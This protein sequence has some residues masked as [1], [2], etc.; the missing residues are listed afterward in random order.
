MESEQSQNFNE[1]LSQWVAN[2]GF[3]FQVR[4]S[5]ASNGMKGAAMYHLLRISFRLLVFLLVATAGYWV[6]LV[7]RTESEAYMETMRVSLQNG[8]SG[9]NSEIRGFSESQGQMTINRFSCE[10]DNQ[11]FFNTLEA[12]NIR[13]K[14]GILDGF[15][16][17]WNP[18]TVSMFRLE[19][20][21]RAGADDAESAANISKA[22]FK[23]FEK[24]QLENIEVT[25]ASIRWGYSE[26]T[27]GSIFNSLM[28]VQILDQ[29]MKLHFKG[30]TFSQ[31]WLKKLEIVNLV[32]SCDAEGMLF[33]TAEFRYGEGT[34][35][36]SGLRVQGGER[37][38]L[39]GIAKIRNLDLEC[40][41]AP[42]LRNFVQGSI[43]GD[44]RVSGSTNSPEGVGFEGM[45]ALDGNDMIT[46]RERIYLLKALSVVDYVRNY[47]RADFREG[48]F[49]I[50]TGSGGMLVTN[51][52]LKATDLITLE[53]NMKVRLPTTQEMEATLAR[54]KN[55]GGAPLF[56]T[57]EEEEQE[58]SNL[59]DTKS[60]E[61][62]FTLGRAARESRKDS[63]DEVQEAARVAMERAGLGSEMRRLGDLAAERLAK[64][65][66]Y[67]GLFKISLLPDSF[68]RAEK[69]AK[70]Y[71]VDS[72]SGRIPMMVPIEGSIYEVTLKQAEEIYQQG[73]R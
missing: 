15:T 36:F 54:G 7:K 14:K 45:V 28:K 25:D 1:R 61:A 68:E 20:D 8:L 52:N 62:D 18:G 24:I 35:D 29:G 10:G 16:S 17:K 58:D 53:G 51:V 49:E 2:Q 5:M 64:T 21:L 48:S 33:E 23:K 32:V 11:T 3:W 50:K 26:R 41:I 43:S 40:M 72:T 38:S 63:N 65:L 47:H 71:P 66:R 67:E 56:V 9:K 59:I 39:R 37:P 46:L 30:G 6:Y 34:L 31:N 42:A 55:A 13:A 73:T 27:R 70:Q 44:F 69:L 12:R 57:G 4:Y 22:L 60:V 19:L